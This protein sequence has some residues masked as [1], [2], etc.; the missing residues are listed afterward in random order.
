MHHIRVLDLPSPRVLLTT[1]S[2]VFNFWVYGPLLS[3]ACHHPHLDGLR[4]TS[5]DDYL[6]STST[7]YY[8][9]STI[10]ASIVYPCPTSLT[11]EDFKFTPLPSFTT[12][13]AVFICS[14]CQTNLFVTQVEA[15]M[16]SV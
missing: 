8:L 5:L 14:T 2:S 4:T 9:P 11:P 10:S 15:L 7:D 1:S 6:F 12:T 13:G 3:T 16:I